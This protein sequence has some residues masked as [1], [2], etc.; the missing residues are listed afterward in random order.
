MGSAFDVV[1]GT[2]DC[3]C[4]VCGRLGLVLAHRKEGPRRSFDVSHHLSQRRRLNSSSVA[5]HP[6]AT[7]SQT[8]PPFPHPAAETPPKTKPIATTHVAIHSQEEGEDELP[9]EAALHCVLAAF[10]A[11]QGPGRELQ[12]DEGAFVSALYR[13]LPDLLRPESGDA[14]GGGRRSASCVALVYDCL[15]AALGKR[16]ELSTARVAAMIKRL[17]SVSLQMTQ[18]GGRRDSERAVWRRARPVTGR[19]GRGGA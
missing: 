19:G 18:V 16:R 9:L 14:S 4:S 7:P 11:L 15:D 1:G 17:L 3:G 13:R 10:R 6:T 8:R 2:T 5:R 12:T